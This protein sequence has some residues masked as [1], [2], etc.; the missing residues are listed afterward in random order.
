MGEKVRGS[1]R[2]Q[3]VYLRDGAQRRSRHLV[4]CFVL[5]KK[6]S[7]CADCNR[8]FAVLP[9]PVYCSTVTAALCFRLAQGAGG[10]RAVPA[11]RRG[12]RARGGRGV[13]AHQHRQV[14]WVRS[15]FPL[16]TIPVRMCHVPCP[17]FSL[18]GVCP[19]CRYP[20]CAEA[21]VAFSRRLLV[22]PGPVLHGS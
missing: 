21:G 7:D 4:G 19:C 16:P 5:S 15:P 22:R 18:C 13:R 1:G 10:D 20:L 3:G 8:C 12:D 11:R 9:G 2:D 6:D 17:G 14:R